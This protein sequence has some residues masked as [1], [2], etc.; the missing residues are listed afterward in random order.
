M[1]NWNDGVTVPKCA[2]DGATVPNYTKR[3]VQRSYRAIGPI[4][5]FYEHQKGRRKK[6]FFVK[7]NL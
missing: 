3:F 6:T 7:Q 1:I 4:I 5:V 2:D